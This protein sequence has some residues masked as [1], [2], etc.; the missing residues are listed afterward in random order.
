M[1]VSCGC[2]SNVISRICDG[3]DECLKA[4][5]DELRKGADFIKIMAGGGVASPTDKL[6][7]L[8]FTPEEIRAIVKA[9]NSSG[10]YVTAH[11]Y[12]THSIRQ[13]VENGVRGI[14][15]G[16]LIDE[17]TAALMADH[18]AYLTPTL[19][20]YKIMASEPF[21]KFLPEASRTKNAEV[22][23]SGLKSLAIAKN[24]G[25]KICYGSDLLGPLIAAQTGEFLLR[26]AVCKPIEIL[27]QA[28]INPAKLFGM[29]NK[30]GQLKPGF[31]ADLIILNSNPLEDISILDKPDRHLLAVMKG[32]R[33]FKSRWTKLPSDI[34]VNDV[35]M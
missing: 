25:V 9:A 16:N 35:I 33:I 28:T 4:A 31:Y 3:A 8:Q 14:E 15:H 18:D 32:G 1:E 26:S 23:A 24:A 19:I 34:V 7:S 11:A 2:Q 17:S 12:T 10:T 20:T 30:L 5:R 22:L 21:S 13:C 6:S 29:E 27:Q